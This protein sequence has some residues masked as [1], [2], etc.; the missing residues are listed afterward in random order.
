[1]KNISD[2]FN[3]NRGVVDLISQL[4]NIFVNKLKWG[5]VGFG[6]CMKNQNA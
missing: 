1:M 3:N 5:F 6:F 2:V 4:N